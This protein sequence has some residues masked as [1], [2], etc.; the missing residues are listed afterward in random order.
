MKSIPHDI[1]NGFWPH[2]NAHNTW[3][4][5]DIEKLNDYPRLAYNNDWPK[6]GIHMLLHCM[7]S[8]MLGRG[9]LLIIKFD[10]LF[11][12]IIPYTMNHWSCIKVYQLPK[13][14]YGNKS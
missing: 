5:F 7:L 3:V 11:T 8:P 14:Q 9:Y 12:H 2:Q 4:S 6:C 1:E 13:W 10:M